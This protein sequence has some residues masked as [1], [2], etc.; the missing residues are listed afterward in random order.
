MLKRDRREYMRNYRKKQKQ[1]LKFHNWTGPKT[2]LEEIEPSLKAW[3]DRLSER[4]RSVAE[5]AKKLKA[6][7]DKYRA[8]WYRNEKCPHNWDF[9]L[10][11]RICQKCGRVENIP[12]YTFHCLGE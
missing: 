8:D 4:E 9:C 5:D 10:G 7:W 6:L 12:G 11:F 2:A 1:F 3:S